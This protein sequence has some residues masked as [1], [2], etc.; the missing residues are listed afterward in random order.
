MDFYNELKTGFNIRVQKKVLRSNNEEVNIY[1][2][3][4]TLKG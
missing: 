2:F 4:G 1:L 3:R